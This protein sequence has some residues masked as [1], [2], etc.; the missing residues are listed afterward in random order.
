[1]SGHSVVKE[2]KRATQTFS[3]I[4]KKEVKG[5]ALLYKERQRT[6]K[7]INTSFEPAPLKEARRQSVRYIVP[8]SDVDAVSFDAQVS[9]LSIVHMALFDYSAPLQTLS[10]SEALLHYP[11]ALAQR[12][13]SNSLGLFTYPDYM[14]E[15]GIWL[16]YIG[17]L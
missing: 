17:L 14:S 8:I 16:K 1:V 3:R 12:V 9:A 7:S 10:Y 5:P 13:L 2:L 6:E 4:I 15:L 11:G